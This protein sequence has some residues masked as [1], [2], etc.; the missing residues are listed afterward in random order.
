MWPGVIIPPEGSGSAPNSLTSSEQLIRSDR[1]ISVVTWGILIQTGLLFWSSVKYLDACNRGR[2][3]SG[4]CSLWLSA[5]LFKSNFQPLVVGRR[6]QK[7][8]EQC[9]SVC[10]RRGKE[11]RNNDVCLLWHR[12]CFLCCKEKKN[13]TVGFFWINKVQEL[14][15]LHKYSYNKLSRNAI[16]VCVYLWL[17]K[18]T[19]S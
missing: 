5:E 19:N 2:W 14:L 3:G 9:E 15:N 12:N 11:G 10:R 16:F 13:Q 17:L 6:Q 8:M 7:E 1:I 18:L 4:T